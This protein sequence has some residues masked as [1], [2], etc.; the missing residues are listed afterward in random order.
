[1]Q[2]ILIKQFIYIIAFVCYMAYY[3]FYI[4]FTYYFCIIVPSI[5]V[6]RC[7][8]TGWQWFTTTILFLWKIQP[9]RARLQPA[10]CATV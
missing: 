3:T 10:G 5:H 4:Y 2:L 8:G 7:I 9:G 1:M 6:L